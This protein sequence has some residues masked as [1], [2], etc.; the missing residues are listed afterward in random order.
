MLFHDKRALVAL[1]GVALG[2]VDKELAASDIRGFSEFKRSVLVRFYQEL[3]YPESPLAKQ[4]V[5]HN[6][7]GAGDFPATISIFDDEVRRLVSLGKKDVE[8]G[9][10]Y[11][12]CIQEW[13]VDGYLSAIGLALEIGDNDFA[14]LN[15]KFV[16]LLHG[17]SDVKVLIFMSR[18]LGEATD[19][20]S[21]LQKTF[22]NYYGNGKP[23][24]TYFICS[25]VLESRRLTYEVLNPPVETDE[26]VKEE[27]E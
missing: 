9:W 18:T 16:K 23:G 26:E 20:S 1:T 2:K 5:E 24:R 25:W 21:S 10:I 27:E 17:D 7:F 6:D 13:S 8:A 14:S 22:T 11:D 3:S 15:L 19:Y 12:L 4:L